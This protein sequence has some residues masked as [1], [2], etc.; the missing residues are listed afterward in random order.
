[1]AGRAFTQ[2]NGELTVPVFQDCGQR[3][4]CVRIGLC[5]A[6]DQQCAQAALNGLAQPEHQRVGVGQ[7]DS[8]SFGE[9]RAVQS[10]P[11]RQLQQFAVTV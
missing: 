8:E 7:R 11:V 6:R 10:V 1:M 5:T 9:F 3:G 2:Q 4:A